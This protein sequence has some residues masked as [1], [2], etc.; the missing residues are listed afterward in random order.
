MPTLSDDFEQR[1]LDFLSRHQLPVEFRATAADFY[2]PLARKLPELRAKTGP[3]F[4]GINGAQGTGKSTLA[5]FL[6]MATN[7][8]F[9]RNVAVL[10]VDDFYFTLDER[11]E[12]ARNVHPLLQTRGVPGTHDLN[13]LEQCL[14]RLRQASSDDAVS[15]PRFDK[16]IDDRANAAHWPV[17]SGS[18]DLIIL[19]GWCVGSQAVPD[20]ALEEP[21]NALERDE[22]KNFVWRSYANEQLRTR[23]A[24]IYALL[25][26]LVF[27]K[28]PSFDAI[29]RWRLE[30]EEKLA[31]ISE[32][33]SAGLM[34][35][36]QIERFI[37]FYERIT[38][39]N[40]E[41]LASDA[42][43]VFELDESHKVIA[44][45]FKRLE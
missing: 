28:A 4:L 1:L 35:R 13:L 29:L 27:L 2:L 6:R 3:L 16:A 34:K 39:A 24:P 45:R 41:M 32:S 15:I 37:L 38:R 20:A 18:V 5:D 36:D 26:A 12:L 30:Q 9:G 43:I 42:E 25:D 11:V 33:D 14:E 7:R 40:L 17:V 10:S 19:E 44:S 23:Y 8:L 22:D 31:A 21:V